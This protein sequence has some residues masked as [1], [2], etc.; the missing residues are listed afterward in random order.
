MPQAAPPPA[1]APSATP[2]P[3]QPQAT[4]IQTAPTPISREQAEFLRV[5]RSALSSQLESAQDRRDEVAEQ[6]RKED[7]SAAERPGLE[8]RLKVLDERLL[9][10]EKDIA[11]N[12]E[13]L[14]NAPPRSRSEAGTAAPPRGGFPWE[15]ANPNLM[16]IFGFALLMPF[17]IHLARRIFAPNRGPSRAPAELAAV[18]ARLDKMESAID[19]VAIEI[20]RVG[21]AQRF[22]TAAMTERVP[23]GAEA[24]PAGLP[25]AEPVRINVPQSADRAPH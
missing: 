8:S 22:M 3:A 24:L 13:Q 17:A 14:A 16:L 18:Q 20:E 19:A 21:E 15:N 9:E 5:R 7:L 11:S 23:R 2:A 4:T 1:Q 10:L 25:P 12:S 6:L